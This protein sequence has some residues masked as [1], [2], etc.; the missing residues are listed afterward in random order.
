MIQFSIHTYST[1]SF[2]MSLVI[3]TSPAP[4]THTYTHEH[5]HTHIHTF[6]N[7]IYSNLVWP[8]SLV[9]RRVFERYT[10]VYMGIPEMCTLRYMHCQTLLV[11]RREYT[12]AKTVRRWGFFFWRYSDGQ[13][14]N[15]RADEVRCR[16]RVRSN[17]HKM[18]R[19]NISVS[20]TNTHTHTHTHTHTRIH[21]Q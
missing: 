18:V 11:Q 16:R 5:T 19:T 17:L 6:D 10:Y 21:P 14:E 1:V 15:G 4:H 8:R 7:R 13:F 12:P 9:F 20:H 3:E 2:N